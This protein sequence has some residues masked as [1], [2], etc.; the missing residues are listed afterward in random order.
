MIRA[1]TSG[2]DKDGEP[3][4]PIMP[5]HRY[6]RLAREDVDA[7]VAYLRTLKPITYT[8]PARELGMPLSLI[9]RTMPAHAEFRPIP[10]ATER[11]AYG[12]YM[13][14]AA[15]C[16]DCHTP[17]DEQGAP[18]PGREYAGGFEMK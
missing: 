17:I 7:I 16:A 6:A 10:P 18:L 12:E 13:I 14:N 11:V 4:V 8:P 2:V 3:L 1:F 15:V 9:V 5:Y